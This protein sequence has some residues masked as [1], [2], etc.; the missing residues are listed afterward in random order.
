MA[1]SRQGLGCTSRLPR[2]S[3]AI[4]RSGPRPAPLMEH[5]RRGH[6]RPSPMPN[7]FAQWGSGPLRR[8]EGGDLAGAF[9]QL[10]DSWDATVGGKGLEHGLH[11]FVSAGG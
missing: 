10:L 6:Q 4:A 8:L 9:F 5:S 7:T 2:V 1:A 11:V 3:R